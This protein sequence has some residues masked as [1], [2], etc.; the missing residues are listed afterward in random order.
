MELFKNKH[1]TNFIRKA[2]TCT[3]PTRFHQSATAM[4]VSQPTNSQNARALNEIAAVHISFGLLY[5]TELLIQYANKFVLI[6]YVVLNAS[7]AGLSVF[8]NLHVIGS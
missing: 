1:Q 8:K 5:F 4:A 7:I 6:R 3:H 2:A